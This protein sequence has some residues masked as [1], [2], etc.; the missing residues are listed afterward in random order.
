[1]AFNGDTE[2][3]DHLQTNVITAVVAD[4]EAQEL[5]EQLESSHRSLAHRISRLEKHIKGVMY[6]E[7]LTLERDNR[8]SR[9][10][11]ELNATKE[12]LAFNATRQDATQDRLH[13]SLLELLESVENL[14]DRVDAYQPEVRKEI[15]KIEF[16]VARI[17][18]SVAIIKEDQVRH[19]LN[20][21]IFTISH[22]K[23]DPYL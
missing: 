16:A 9:L 20:E 3:H 12:A 21:F 22:H 13:G 23:H 14:D 10:E 6:R 8:L 18:A 4:Q 2:N 7:S 15:S 11:A 19:I 5:Q 1:V 17:N